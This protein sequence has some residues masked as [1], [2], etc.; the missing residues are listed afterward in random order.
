MRLMRD[1]TIRRKF[2]GFS[3]AVATLTIALLGLILS[4]LQMEQAIVRAAAV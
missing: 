1:W 2:L 4:L 3:A